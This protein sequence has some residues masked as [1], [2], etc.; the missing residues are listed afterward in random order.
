MEEDKRLEMA[1][2]GLGGVVVVVEHGFL[3]GI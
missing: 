3:G 2:K 1:C